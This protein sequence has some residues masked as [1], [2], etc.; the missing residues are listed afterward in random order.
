MFVYTTGRSSATACS[1][2]PRVGTSATRSTKGKPEH[3]AARSASVVELLFGAPV[4]IVVAQPSSEAGITVESSPVAPCCVPGPMY[5]EYALLYL[6]G[7]LR[8]MVAL[9]WIGCLCCAFVAASGGEELRVD[10]YNY[11]QLLNASN[12]FIVFSSHTCGACRAAQAVGSDTSCL[13]IH[14][15]THS[16]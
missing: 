7:S 1:S 2:V 11:R 9:W 8:L 15:T 4:S 10:K 3:H 6:E 13:T 12:W 5:A 14:N 16:T